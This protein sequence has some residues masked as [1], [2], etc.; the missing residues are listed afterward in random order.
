MFDVFCNDC[1]HIS[2]DSEGV[3]PLCGKPLN[4][5]PHISDI[6]SGNIMICD[7]C[8]AMNVANANFCRVCG[9]QKASFE[10]PYTADEL[11]AGSQDSF[12][13]QRPFQTSSAENGDFAEPD[14]EFRQSGDDYGTST[15]NATFVPVAGRHESLL[16]RLDR[17]ERELE[18][19]RRAPLP[20]SMLSSPDELDQH[21]ETLKSI[22][23]TLDSLITDLLE[24]EAGEYAFP[25]FVS[26]E[27]TP[28][29]AKDEAAQPAREADNKQEH[30]PD[31]KSKR[32]QEILMLFTLIAAIFMVGLSFGLWGSFFF[33]R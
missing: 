4:Q 31:K 13:F 16:E 15:V 32:V 25:G 26:P 29:E 20:E 33:G 17:M 23:Y 27:E 1:G 24:A 14:G 28:S 21:E 2:T 12:V 7:A 8:S 22:A 30:E 3:C 6:T 18:E 10:V 5:E 9:N 19:S 11:S